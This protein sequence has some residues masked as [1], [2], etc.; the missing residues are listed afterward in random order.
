MTNAQDQPAIGREIE[1]ELASTDRIDLVLA[2]IRWT[3]VRQFL[4][5]L[6]RHVKNKK[7]PSA[8]L[9]RY[10]RAVLNCVLSRLLL[11]SALI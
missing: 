9:L 10:I 11:N 2:F 8:L 7:N 4:P 1:A 6:R 5:S 3:G